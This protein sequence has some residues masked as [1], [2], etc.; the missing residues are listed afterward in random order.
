MSFEPKRC[1]G[2]RAV[3]TPAEDACYRG[4]CED[5]Y[6][7]AQPR[8]GHLNLSA[9]AGLLERLGARGYDLTDSAAG[10]RGAYHCKS[11]TGAPPAPGAPRGGRTPAQRERARQ[12]ARAAWAKRRADG[13]A[14][15]PKARKK[16]T[17]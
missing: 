12:A 6:S 17:A 9:G 11:K 10:R 7:G 1:P 2:C 5:C 15:N 8:G 4:R 13:T 3:L 16:V 14:T